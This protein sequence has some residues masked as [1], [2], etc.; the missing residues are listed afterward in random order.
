MRIVDHMLE[1]LAA[2]GAWWQV[3]VLDVV[4][5]QMDLQGWVHSRYLRRA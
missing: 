2:R 1:R 5:G 4:N 3:D